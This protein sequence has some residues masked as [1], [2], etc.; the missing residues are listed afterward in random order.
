VYVNV[1]IIFEMMRLHFKNTSNCIH[2][3]LCMRGSH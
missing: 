3:L 2:T 1:I